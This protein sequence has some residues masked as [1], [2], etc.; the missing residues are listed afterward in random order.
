MDWEELLEKVLEKYGDAKVKFSSYYKYTFTFR[1]KTEDGR[2]IVCRVGW[3][4]DDIY[5]FGVN[6]EE[7]ITVRDLHPDEIEVDDEVIWSNRWW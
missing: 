1:G 6:A 3:T 2:E 7:E 5:R 4:A